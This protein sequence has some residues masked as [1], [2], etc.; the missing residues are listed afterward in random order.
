MTE[1]GPD[2]NSVA[3]PPYLSLRRFAP[4]FGTHPARGRV[5]GGLNLAICA[6]RVSRGAY[7]AA[8]CST[9]SS[10]RFSA[11]RQTGSSAVPTSPSMMANALLTGIAAR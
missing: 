5:A 10:P 2:Q 7:A 1:G 4:S 8:A 9:A 3:P 11:A 6:V